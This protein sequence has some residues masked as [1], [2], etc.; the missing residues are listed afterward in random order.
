MVLC[1]YE[2]QSCLNFL[3]NSPDDPSDLANAMNW[4][5]N[6]AV[7]VKIFGEKN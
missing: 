4:E 1:L 6:L 2:K 3:F 7:G 5:T